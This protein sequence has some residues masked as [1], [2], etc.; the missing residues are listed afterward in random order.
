MTRGK[1]P[2]PVEGFSVLYMSYWTIAF[3]DILTLRFRTCLVCSQA[4]QRLD[5]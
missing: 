1:S 4:A 2:P 3:D 5:L